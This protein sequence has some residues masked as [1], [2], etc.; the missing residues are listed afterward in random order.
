[1]IMT[2]REFRSLFLQKRRELTDADVLERS[3]RIADIFFRTVD[4]SRVNYLHTF[5]PLKK[6]KEPDTW[7]IIRRVKK[8]FSDVSV[9][10]P[11]VNPV[12]NAMENYLFARDEDLELSAWGIQ[13][14]QIGIEVDAGVIDMV[15]V[16]LLAFDLKGHRVGY[17]KGFYDR[18][19]SDCRADC[20]R[21]GISL[22]D[23]VD[24]ISD[25]GSFDEP[26]HR[27]ITPTAML[28]F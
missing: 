5:L 20:I 14:P 4:L 27:C 15:L 12:T 13:E 2:K 25:V 24:Q 8:E 7:P 23:P 11:R 3:Q 1:M 16:P 21:I 19:L 6:N 17:G 10:L 26:L 28:T 9:I 18:F 22:F